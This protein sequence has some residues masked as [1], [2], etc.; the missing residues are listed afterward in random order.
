MPLSK[1]IIK[2]EELQCNIDTDAIVSV[3]LQYRPSYGAGQASYEG[4]EP[5][6][7]SEQKQQELAYEAKIEAIRRKSYEEG[8][9]NRTAVYTKEVSGYI[10]RIISIIDELSRLKSVVIKESEEEILRLALAIAKSILRQETK[11][12]REYLVPILKEIILDIDKNDGLKI[13]LNP[14]DLRYITEVKKDFVQEIEGLRN[15]VLEEDTSIKLGGVIIETNGGEIDA[16]LEKQ[17]I[18]LEKDLLAVLGK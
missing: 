13:R 3:L 17:I 1:R 7:I 4:N 6:N 16:R 9:N 10:G 2:S 15:F 18:E 5:D 12:N 14:E 8:Y 11:I